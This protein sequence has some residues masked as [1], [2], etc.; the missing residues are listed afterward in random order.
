[1]RPISLVG[2]A[3]L[4]AVGGLLA[5]ACSPSSHVEM[6]GGGGGTGAT[7]STGGTGGSG[8]QGICLLHNCNSDIECATCDSGRTH[9]LT[10]E[11][12]CVA[13]G[14]NTT[15]G[16]PD[17]YEC[18]S[19]GQCVPMGETCPTSNG[20]PTIS[21]NSAA[22]CVACDPA[23]QVCDPATHQCVACTNND[24]S[25]CQSTDLCLN[26]KCAPKCP[27]GCQTD[28]DCAQCGTPQAPAHACNAHNCAQC[29]PT[30]ACAAGY[31]CTPHGTCEKRC[32]LQGE[33]EG[34]CESDA[35]CA[36]CQGGSTHCFTPLNGG[37]GTCVPPA[38]GCSDLG[39]GA[40]TLPEPF[41]K[42]TNLC[43]HDSDCANVGIEYNVGKLLRDLTGFDEIN[44]ANID[45]GMHVC[46]AVDITDNISCGVCVPCAV[47][48]DCQPI[49]I[50]Q[51]SGQL[52]GTLG[53]V[54]AALLL[55]K[56]F[57]PNDHKIHMYCQTVALG[58]GV[59]APCPGILSDCTTGGSTGSGSCGHD[60]C[61][62]GDP[63]DPSCGGCESTVCTN[64]S[65]CCSTA[66]DS[67]CVSEVDQYCNGIC[68]NPG[69]ACAHS[70]CTSGE[71][72]AT[73]CSGCAA[74]VCGSDAFCC[75]TSWDSQCVSE[76]Q[77]MCGSTCP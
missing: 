40:L 47:D 50:D 37:H 33:V 63:L 74:T 29:S 1:M 76:A 39:A 64:D 72:L 12:R 10:T 65:Y 58:Y 22:D 44:D 73:S 42:V 28:N 15:S 69:G 75:Q 66:W 21:C 34:T 57:G 19:F 55:D 4:L 30:Y 9:C 6:T 48:S 32:G 36:G 5:P 26:G 2:F 51:L 3:A 35:D 49:A 24:T 56:I 59:C 70:A 46:A 53:S 38:T 43:S 16:C 41:D 25:E 54:G 61:T 45:Y 77:S 31:E 18:S 17:G 11:H 62:A 27:A 13:C 14:A 67:A 8:E 52:F 20:V 68:S 7:A 23:H 71:A 60:A